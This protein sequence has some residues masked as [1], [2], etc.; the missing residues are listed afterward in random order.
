MPEGVLLI[1]AEHADRVVA[2]AFCLVGDDTLYGRHWGCH[3][4]FDMLHFEACYY[5][6]IDYCIRHRL[7]RFEPGAQG[8]H[9]IAR[10]FL[11][12]Q[13]LSAHWLADTR[14]ADA[15]SRHLEYE[16]NGMQE[17]IREMQGRSPYRSQE[18]S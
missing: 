12:T 2:A 15:I 1:M 3:E 18:S 8:E 11:P 10:G 17:Y 13:T 7:A 14:F 4:H 5:Q 9:K 16:R 6:G